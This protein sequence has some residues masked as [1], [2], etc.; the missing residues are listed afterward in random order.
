MATFNLTTSFDD[1]LENAQRCQPFSRLVPSHRMRL[2][3]K[4]QSCD[5]S[6]FIVV[7][8]EVETVRMV[9]QHSVAHTSEDVQVW[10][11]R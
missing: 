3:A 8:P 10:F 7:G 11:L 6:S 2:E 4:Y 1:R 9:V 5:P